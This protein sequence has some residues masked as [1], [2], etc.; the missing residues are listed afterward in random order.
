MSVFVV[1]SRQPSIG[2]LGTLKSILVCMLAL[3]YV[4][5]CFVLSNVSC[6]SVSGVRR[7]LQAGH[8]IGRTGGG[9]GTVT[10]VHL[11]LVAIISYILGLYL[12]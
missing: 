2:L 1:H 10:L 12:H 11:V 8:G 6:T 5:S 4:F 9:G 3:I 7:R